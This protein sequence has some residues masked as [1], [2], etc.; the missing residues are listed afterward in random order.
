MLRRA[1]TERGESWC[2]RASKVARTMLYGLDELIDEFALFPLAAIARFTCH[3]LASPSRLDLSEIEPALARRLRQR[4][5]PA[6]VKVT[7][8]I[9]HNLLDTLCGCALGKPF[10]HRFRRFDIGASFKATAHLLFE[11]GG[12]NNGL[13]VR[14]V[15]DLRINVL[16]R[17]EDGQP[18][19]RAG[20]AADLAPHFRGPSQRPISACRH[21]A[22]SLLFSFFAE[23]VLVRVFDAFA[24][25]R[26]GLAEGADYGGHMANLLLINAGDHDL[27]RPEHRDRNAFRDRIDDVV[28]ITELN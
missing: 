18:R 2:L 28:A 26:L 21:G 15:D 25:V 9:E 4:L 17:A 8:T 23:D 13:A 7:A 19:A 20:G 27:G 1:A 22:L 3:D 11:R 16:G 6:V 24:F 5:D 14:I 12:G 10:S